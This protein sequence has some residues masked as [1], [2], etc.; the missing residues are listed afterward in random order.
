MNPDP[1]KIDQLRS[2]AKSFGYT[3]RHADVSELPHA[4]NDLLKDVKGT[5]E[6]KHHQAGRDPEHGE[7]HL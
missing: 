5:E 1:E 4:I 3:L 2:L 7:S 6:E